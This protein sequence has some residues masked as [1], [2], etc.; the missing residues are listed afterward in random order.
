[1]RGALGHQDPEV[2]LGLGPGADADHRDP[3]AGRERGEVARHV[4]AA[5]ELE[6]DVERAVLLEALGVDGVDVE[7]VDA[8][9]QVGVAHGGGDARA[10]HLAELDRGHADAARGAVD[11]QALAGP[12]AGLGEERVVGGREDL[13][14]AARGLPVE[15]LGHRH[16]GALVDDRELGLAAAGDDRH[17]AVA[18]LEALHAR[19]ALDHLAGQLE[20]GDVLRRAGRRR[21]AALELLD[22]GAVEPGAAHAHEQ[23]GVPGDRIGVLLDGDRAVPDRGRAHRWRSYLSW[24][25]VRFARQADVFM[26]IGTYSEGYRTPGQYVPSPCNTADSAHVAGDANRPRG[27]RAAPQPGLPRP[28]AA[29]GRAPPGAA[30]PGLHGRRR[31]A[32]DD[33]ELAAA[34]RLLHPPHRHPRQ[35]RLLGGGLPPPRGAA[36]A[37]GR[38]PRRARRGHRPEPRRGL[39]PRARRPAA[40]ARLGDRDA[41]LADPGDARGAPARARADRPRQRA[42]HRPPPRACSASAACA[43][44]AARTSGPP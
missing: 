17:H 6:H 4:R 16:G 24:P 41:R 14:H 13:G 1:M 15:L 28:R 38:A 39:R 19:T 10:R 44:S 27:R 43:A 37:H 40:G 32:R 36:R 23:V 33:G 34:G 31:L 26:R 22:V 18:D 12:Q 21:I 2:E 3:A 9:A 7:R 42:R 35:P 8:L 29:A 11:E 30:D 25:F 20:A 5:D